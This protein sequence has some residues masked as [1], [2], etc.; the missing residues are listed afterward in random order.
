MLDFGNEIEPDVPLLARKL[1]EG[2]ASPEDRERLRPPRANSSPGAAAMHWLRALRGHA[3]LLDLTEKTRLGSAFTFRD[4][5][6][7]IPASAEGAPLSR[8]LARGGLSNVWGAA[9]Y[10]LVASDYRHWPFREEE[11]AP[12]YASAA[13][14]LGLSEPADA[15]ADVYPIYGVRSAGLPLNPTSDLLLHHWNTMQ[16]RLRAAGI[17]FGRARLAVRSEDDA[18]GW[19]CQQCGLCLEGCPYD[20]IYRSDWTL[21][22][23]RRS[24]G[25]RYRSGFWVQKFFERR[26]DVTVEA[27]VNPSGEALQLRYD[28]LFLAAGT[29]SSLRI[30]AESLGNEGQPLRILDNDLF[31][32]PL[33][34]TGGKPLEAEPL[35][36]SLN[37]LALRF[38]VD[39]TPIHA[40]IYSMSGAVIDRFRPLVDML[41]GPLRRSALSLL[42]RTMLGFIYLPGD[43]STQ[44]EASI[45][46][47][48][49][50]SKVELRQR[51][52]PDS[53]RIVRRLLG[54]LYRERRALGLV[55]IGPAFRSTPAGHSG[56]HLSGGLPMTLD[57]GPLQTGIDGL[58]HGA[59]N[60]YVTDAA[61]LPHLPAQNSTYTIMAN[62]QRI[63]SLYL[64]RK[65]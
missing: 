28:A 35:R 43:R 25:F 42:A 38:E 16:S 41:P 4:T 33:L 14:L 9:C 24:G 58:L 63:A 18:E 13:K 10:P 32:V 65:S 55:P 45:V 27:V 31:L 29:L 51:R 36:F 62:A 15:L 44:I 56:G 20:A 47:S 57:P 8:S 54:R 60:V 22:E 11:L 12:H 19:G 39:G 46:P 30:A 64:S 1:R 49:P 3:P 17:Y 5:E 34:R 26:E 48:S 2:T 23:L 37:E 7:G 40:Q 59:G 50:V 21:G 6:W 53:P 61:A 52:S